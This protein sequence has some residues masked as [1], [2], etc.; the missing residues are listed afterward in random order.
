VEYYTSRQ[1]QFSEELV[2]AGSND[3]LHL[4]YNV[5]AFYFKE[6]ANQVFAYIYDLFITHTPSLADIVPIPASA[7]NKSDGLYTNLTW[8]PPISNERLDITLGGRYSRDTRAVV[9]G[10]I[11]GQGSKSYKSVDPSATIDYRWS[12]DVHTY[13]KYSRAYRAGGFNIFNTVLH[14]FNPERLTSYEVG[15]K[16]MWWENRLRL[17]LD[18]FTQDYKDIQIDQIVFDSTLGIFVTL[19]KNLS[20]ARYKGVES[21][22][23]LLP[24]DRLR[25]S[26]DVTF[27]QAETVSGVPQP[28]PNAPKWKGN[29]AVEYSFDP[30]SF[31][32]LSGLVG[33]SYQGNQLSGRGEATP[34]YGLVNARLTLSGL[35][36]GGDRGGL[37]VALWGQN[38]VDRHYIYYKSSGGIIYGEPRTFG[39]NAVYSY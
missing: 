12:D 17:N 31:G 19:T 1:H 26:T 30:F 36:A 2:L 33:W 35:R 32:S 23:E 9:G 34:G 15:M 10:F 20:K 4:K 18:V 29:A 16:S 13:V 11:P 37:S 22:L 38:L 21:E 7:E 5:G 39:I 6:S 27:M 8:T 25:L 14:P 24:T 3:E 28:L